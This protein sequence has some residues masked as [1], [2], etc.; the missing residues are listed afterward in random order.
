MIILKNKKPTTI[1]L[2]NLVFL[3]FS[4]RL[5]KKQ[6]ELMNQNINWESWTI[7]HILFYV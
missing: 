4:N 6:M 3:S 5:T 2:N 1:C 7:F